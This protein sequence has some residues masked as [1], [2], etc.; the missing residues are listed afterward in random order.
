MKI[1]IELNETKSPANDEKLVLAIS[2]VSRK[3]L[4]KIF[5][6]KKF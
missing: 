6:K 1:I 4:F 3:Y 5:I 2:D